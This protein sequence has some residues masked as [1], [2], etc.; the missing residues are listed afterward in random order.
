MFKQTYNFFIKYTLRK[1]S[2]LLQTDK[3]VFLKHFFRSCKVSEMHIHAYSSL[4]EVH[5]VIRN[6]Y[7]I[8]LDKPLDENTMFRVSENTRS[9]TVA[10]KIW[11]TKACLYLRIYFKIIVLSSLTMG[12]RTMHSE[13]WSAFCVV[14]PPQ[15]ALFSTFKMA[16][17]QYTLRSK[18]LIPSIWLQ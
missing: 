4:K 11:M 16:V 17:I 13:L 10:W 15:C 5:K 2:P 1:V 7:L 8:F 6:S 18:L 14:I 9:Q 12:H 3:K